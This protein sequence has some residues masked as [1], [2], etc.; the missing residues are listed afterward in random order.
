MATSMGTHNATFTKWTY[1][2]KPGLKW[3]NGKAVSPLDIKYGLERL[4][5]TDVINGGPA[6]YFIQ[7]IQHPATYKG[8]YKSGDLKHDHDHRQHRSRST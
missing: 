1:T 8:P 5:A 2:L 6:S 7:G 4:F 3:S